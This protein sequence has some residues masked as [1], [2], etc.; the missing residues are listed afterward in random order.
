MDPVYASSNLTMLHILG[1][2][3]L[4]KFF[5]CVERYELIELSDIASDA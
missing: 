2:L 1:H 5:L 3:T 4:G